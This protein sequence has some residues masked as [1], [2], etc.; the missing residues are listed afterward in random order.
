MYREKEQ[1]TF[2]ICLNFFLENI[3]CM[4]F[5]VS[6]LLFSCSVQFSCFM[7][8][9][10]TT[11]GLSWQSLSVRHAKAIFYTK[12]LAASTCF[13]RAKIWVKVPVGWYRCGCG[14]EDVSDK[15]LSVAEQNREFSLFV[16]IE[17]C[18]TIHSMICNGLEAK[19]E[20]RGHKSNYSLHLIDFF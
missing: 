8:C 2:P 15:K 11:E 18:V 17:S 20:S 19:L 4:Q 13:V 12:P 1:K 5:C 6:L 14:V 7:Q 16:P 3:C 10:Q 9:F